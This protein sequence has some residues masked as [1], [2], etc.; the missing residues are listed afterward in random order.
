M[1]NIFKLFHI[2]Y[3]MKKSI[4]LVLAFLSVIML[5]GCDNSLEKLVQDNM[6]DMRINYFSGENDL[7]Y[8]ELSCGYREQNFAYDGVSCDKVE[9]GV[10]SVEFKTVYSY[11]YISIT[12]SIDENIND[13]VLKL[14]PFE[15]KYM[16]DIEQIVSENS[17]I[18][19]KLKNQDNT[20]SL[21]CVSSSWKTQYKKAIEIATKTLKEDLQN[22]YF[23]GK[24]N[25]ECYLKIIT[26]YDYDK[27]YWYFSFIDR[28]GNTK[29]MLIDVD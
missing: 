4:C 5:S 11:E 14:S 13:Y 26:K 27:T 9:C 8:A 20:C 28:A 21:Q 22:L 16:V 23:N 3:N 19:V 18:D 1:Q 17:Q 7:F 15:N 6:S 24:L 29:S 12:L 2:K 10:L 25:A